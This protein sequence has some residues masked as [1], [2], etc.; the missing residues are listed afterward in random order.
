MRDDIVASS[1]IDWVHTQMIH[2]VFY[3]YVWK[4]DSEEISVE[5]K[6]HHHFQNLFGDLF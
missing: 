3:R 1:L 5:M 6:P 4:R 2:D